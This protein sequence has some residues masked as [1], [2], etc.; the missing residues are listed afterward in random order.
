LICVVS[1]ITGG[2]GGGG[3]RAKLTHLTANYKR[4]AVVMWYRVRHVAVH[5]YQWS[6]GA[7]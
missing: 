6:F 4:V 7:G 5:S 1:E 3:E 2:G